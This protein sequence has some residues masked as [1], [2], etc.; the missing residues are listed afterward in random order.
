M[1]KKV[2]VKVKLQAK[3]GKANPAPPIGTALGPHGI[4]IQEFCK[5]F[6]DKTKEM[7]DVL[8]PAIITIYQDRSFDFILKTPPASDLILKEINL[9]KGSGEPNKTKVGKITKAQLRKIA[10]VK[11]VD[12]NTTS[13]D[14]AIRMIAGTARSMGITVED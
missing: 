10:E 5:Q 12:F 3:A 6:N 14:Q 8:I 13:V 7:G 11:M 1:A 4:N 9:P 2:L